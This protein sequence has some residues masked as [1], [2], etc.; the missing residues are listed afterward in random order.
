MLKRLLA[1]EDQA[2]VAGTNGVAFNFRQ[3]APFLIGFGEI[4]LA[5]V[6]SSFQAVTMAAL[7]TLWTEQLRHPPA[8][9]DSGAWLPRHP[10]VR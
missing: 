4:L 6:N 5:F 3:V 7:H 1:G 10:E 9:F 2:P 8:D